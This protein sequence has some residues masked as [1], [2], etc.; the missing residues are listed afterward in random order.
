MKIG[1][2]QREKEYVREREKKSGKTKKYMKYKLKEIK[3]MIINKEC[4]LCLI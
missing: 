1:K 4:R 2:R 3:E